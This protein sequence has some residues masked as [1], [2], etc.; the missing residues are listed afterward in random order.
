[1]V[2][3]SFD[4]YE[5]TIKKLGPDRYLLE[6]SAAGTVQGNIQSCSDT[7]RFVSNDVH[8]LSGMFLTLGLMSHRHRVVSKSEPMFSTIEGRFVCRCNIDFELKGPTSDVKAVFE[9]AQRALGV[10]ELKL[11]I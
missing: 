3:N 6:V 4:P 1:M 7:L 9:E 8:E 10:V 2:G 5:L 11:E